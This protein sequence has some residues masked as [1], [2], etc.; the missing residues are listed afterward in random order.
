PARGRAL[1]APRPALAAPPA[2]ARARE[3]ARVRRPPPP[4][5]APGGGPA[6]RG[7]VRG[8]PVGRPDDAPAA[9]AHRARGGEPRPGRPRVAPHP[10]RGDRTPGVHLAVAG[11][12][13]RTDPARAPRARRGRRSEEHTSEL[14]S[15]VD[16]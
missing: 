5:R 9:L 6:G 11:R 12:R 14:Q 3:G 1:A 15:R 8:P 2:H 13:G 4:A 16:L 10:R 7:G